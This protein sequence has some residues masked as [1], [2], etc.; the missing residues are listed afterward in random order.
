[1]RRGSLW[2]NA[3]TSASHA[4]MLV[5]DRAVMSLIASMQTMLC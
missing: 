1:M 2:R 3:P 4:V 5:A